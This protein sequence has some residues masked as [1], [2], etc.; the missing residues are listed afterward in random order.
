MFNIIKQQRRSIT[1]ADLGV[2]NLRFRY[3]KF[4]TKAKLSPRA[5]TQYSKK[6]IVHAYLYVLS[7]QQIRFKKVIR[8]KSLKLNT[9]FK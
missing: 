7:L 1:Y 2:N 8:T 9:F 3:L 4:R 6:N 5:K